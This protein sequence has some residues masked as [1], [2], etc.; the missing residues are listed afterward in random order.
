MISVLAEARNLP[1]SACWDMANSITTKMLEEKFSM[2]VG[3]LYMINEVF[4]HDD[5]ADCSDVRPVGRRRYWQL[6]TPPPE[7]QLMDIGAVPA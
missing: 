1:L 7:R 3:P 4:Y 2:T 6:P 5:N